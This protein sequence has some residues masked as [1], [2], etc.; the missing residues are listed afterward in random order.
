MENSKNAGIKKFI[1]FAASVL[2][3]F[4]LAF[5]FPYTGDDW[6]WGSSIGLERLAV[7]FK[8]YNGRYLG[9]LLVILLTRSNILKAA[10]MSTVIFSTA[11]LI[12]R[13]VEKK[14]FSVYMLALICF[15]AV[16]R[17]VFRQ[18][19]V[20][21]SGFTNYVVPT[22]LVILYV[23][24][25]RGIFDGK[26]EFAKGTFIATFLIG[27]CA[28]LFIENITIYQIIM[29]ILLIIGALIGYRKSFAPVISHFIGSVVGCVIMFSNG[30][31]RNIAAST[32]QYRTM[33]TTSSGMIGRIKENLYT[34]ISKELALNNVVLN[35]LIALVC[36][37]V[38]IG[39][40]QKNKK[41]SPVKKAFV[42]LNL[43]I[44]VSYAAYSVA[45]ALYQGWNFALN[46][47]KY[48]NSIFV[49]LFGISL[50]ML[51]I[52]CVDRVAVKIRL[53]FYLVSIAVLTAPLF[54][55]TPIGS[56]CFYCS[57]MFFAFFLCEAFNYIMDGKKISVVA[58]SGVFAVIC[59]SFALYYVSVFGYIYKSD[60]ERN[61]YVAQQLSDGKTVVE[62][63][64]L[65]YRG[66]LWNST[67]DPSTVWAERYKKFHG[68]DTDT[69]FRIIG[70]TEW[71]TSV[72]SK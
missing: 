58:V 67:P 62:V 55:V 3:L 45:C 63:P 44:A 43:F 29:D 72:K 11:F 61:A 38:V 21:T 56:R 24:I 13:T 49:I 22:L 6:A 2:F 52:L 18:A 46:Y 5:M 17:Y 37:A 20:W 50:F 39:F 16:P 25:I 60:V 28:A 51:S 30:A 19:V 10:V 8:D 42:W 68:I 47:T 9:N 40:I 57:Y 15:F 4:G 31:Y 14:N 1:V 41:A 48:F 33:E 26:P 54:V 35:I 70:F 65:P 34:V 7:W 27:V 32:D 23:F 12:Y 69:E 36:I 66:Y 64:E 53:C 59:I 71:R